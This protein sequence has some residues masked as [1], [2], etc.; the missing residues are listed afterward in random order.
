MSK[1]VELMA[2]G[3]RAHNRAM[4][5][6]CSDDPRLI[7]V[8]QVP[9]LGP[10][11][12]LE[13]VA[14]AID[15]GCGAVLFPSHPGRGLSPTHPDYDRVWSMLE[16][17]SIPFM[18]HI[19]GAGRTLKPA[20]HDNGRPV[21]DFLGGGE[22][23]RAKDYMA[24]HQVPEQFLSLSCWTECSM[25]IPVCVAVASNKA[26]CGFCLGSADSISRRTPSN[27]RNRR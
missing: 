12:T 5:D 22:N 14:G 4:A 16:E 17:R 3:T 18:L 20:F 27:V 2:G 1:D 6:F 25:R 19:G 21:S 10:E 9:W 23:I 7:A 8:A 11:Q 24:I 13:L 15:G 26:R